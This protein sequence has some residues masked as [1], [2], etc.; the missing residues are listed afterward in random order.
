[1]CT[2]IS[3]SGVVAKAPLSLLQTFARERG[4]T[5]LRFLSSAGNTYNRDYLALTPEGWT[6]PM[7]NV[8]TRRDGVLRHFWGS[9][10]LYAPAD[11]GQDPRHTGTIE[12]VWNL[13][14]LTPEGRGAGSEEQLN[15]ACCGAKT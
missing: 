15:Y 4:W 10:I 9:E 8:F 12:P 11:P 2:S 1:M 14:D 5:R 7:L 6:R 3:I 13:F